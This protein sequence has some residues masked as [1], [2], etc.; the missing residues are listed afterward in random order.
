M[1]G[2]RRKMDSPAVEEFGAGEIRIARHGEAQRQLRRVAD[3]DAT[4]DQDLADAR[5]VVAHLQRRRRIEQIE[6]VVRR[7]SEAE[8]LAEAAG[9]GGELAKRWLGGE[10]AVAL[11]LRESRDW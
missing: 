3:A 7:A 1:D 4:R 10:G 2:I 11:H 8:R 6:A 5:A 9:A